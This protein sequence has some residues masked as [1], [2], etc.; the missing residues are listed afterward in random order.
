MRSSTSLLVLSSAA[1]SVATSDVP[2]EYQQCGSSYYLPDVY[3]CY[4]DTNLCPIIDGVDTQLC[5][6]ACYLPSQY[7]CNDDM[8]SPLS[9]PQMPSGPGEGS[10]S[11][12]SQASTSHSPDE[13]QASATEAVPSDASET[14]LSDPEADS[15]A[16]ETGLESESVT[17]TETSPESGSATAIETNVESEG[18]TASETSMESNTATTTTLAE[19]FTSA[20]PDV[21]NIPSIVSSVIGHAAGGSLTNS[22]APAN[23]TSAGPTNSSSV[24]A[25]FRPRPSAPLTT[26]ASQG[27]PAP[28]VAPP[29]SSRTSKPLNTSI[30]S[31]PLILAFLLLTTGLVAATPT[32]SNS[33]AST[34]TTTTNPL[35]EATAL[36]TIE[37]STG[38]T[39]DPSRP[40]VNRPYTPEVE[41]LPGADADDEAIQELED[42]IKENTA[43]PSSA[44]SH[45][46]PGREW[47]LNEPERNDAWRGV[48]PAFGLDLRMGMGGMEKGVLSS[49]GIGFLRAAGV[50]GGVVTV[51]WMDG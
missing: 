13:G 26:S 4:N 24:S 33:A 47:F 15:T 1:L 42:E 18:D 45:P 7:S 9:N 21:S 51:L 23:G 34:T 16:S 35:D 17:A 50:L 2:S 30:L 31:L 22:T 38:D 5:G 3:I 43:S 27:A 36:P 48:R 44:D 28:S 49:V 12:P 29:N 41:T 39:K 32:P 46:P 40:I 14:P 10:C 37:I 6:A 20:S 8:L 11:C 25:P 19:T